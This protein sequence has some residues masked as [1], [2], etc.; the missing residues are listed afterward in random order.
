[1]FSKTRGL[2]GKPDLD[3]SR[4]GAR[5]P[6]RSF[7]HLHRPGILRGW[8]SRVVV[9]AKGS[10]PPPDFT[11]SRLRARPRRANG[12]VAVRVVSGSSP[13]MPSIAK[14]V[15]T[16]RGS[17]VPTA[18]STGS[19]SALLSRHHYRLCLR[20]WF[21]D[22]IDH[23]LSPSAGPDPSAGLSFSPWAVRTARRRARNRPEQCL[24]ASAWFSKWKP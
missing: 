8:I 21:D 19:H 4:A 12:S 17:G 22:L 16:A 24:P 18:P 14:S 6:E 11:L 1:M 10:S 2:R 3:R 5:A 20:R 23:W 9:S 13:P 7:T 15:A